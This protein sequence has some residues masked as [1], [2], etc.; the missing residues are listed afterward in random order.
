[1]SNKSFEIDTLDIN[2]NET[3]FND[4]KFDNFY[5]EKSSYNNNLIINQFQPYIT[6][7]PLPND[8]NLDLNTF[9]FQDY[10]KT[11]VNPLIIEPVQPYIGGIDIADSSS[12]SNKDDS[13]KSN[14]IWNELI[15][16]NNYHQPFLHY[17]TFSNYYPKSI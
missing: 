13:S 6:A 4:V 10:E 11:I 9:Q 1:M 12:S 2:L 17:N 5:N 7:F 15:N 3:I 14:G 16:Y 8:D